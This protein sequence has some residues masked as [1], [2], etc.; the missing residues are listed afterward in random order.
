MLFCGNYTINNPHTTVEPEFYYLTEGNK[1][2]EGPSRTTGQME[3]E[4]WSVEGPKRN[5]WNSWK[6]SR[7]R[8]HRAKAAVLMSGKKISRI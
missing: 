6:S 3:W 4:R 5:C 7:G 1:A 2:N 8:C